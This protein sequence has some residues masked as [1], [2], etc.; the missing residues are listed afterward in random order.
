MASKQQV[1]ALEWGKKESYNSKKELTE[2][3]SVLK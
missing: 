3:M 2:R 1:P